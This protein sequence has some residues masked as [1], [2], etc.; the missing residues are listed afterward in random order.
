MGGVV[1]MW[2]EWST[3]GRSGP[4]V[5]GVVDMW[6]EWSTCGGSVTGVLILCVVKGRH[7]VELCVCVC[8][9]VCV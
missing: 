2:E 8:V 9:R 6:E 4:R 5:G 3:C 7:G 1:D